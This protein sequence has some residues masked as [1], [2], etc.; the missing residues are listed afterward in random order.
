MKW[1]TVGF[2]NCDDATSLRPI[3][4]RMHLKQTVSVK[5]LSLERT[6]LLRLRLTYQ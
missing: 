3:D 2:I 6:Y 5:G 1:H 4:G